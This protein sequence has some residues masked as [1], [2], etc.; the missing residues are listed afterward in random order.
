MLARGFASGGGER[1]M[2]PRGSAED[3]APAPLEARARRCSL[4]SAD[5]AVRRAVPF[6]H[7]KPLA[8]SHWPSALNVLSPCAIHLCF[9]F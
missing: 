4:R 8:V 5:F 2:A 6:N 1:R 3:G 9:S 7:G